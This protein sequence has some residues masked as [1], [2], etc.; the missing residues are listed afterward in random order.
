MYHR[1]MTKKIQ[2]DKNIDLTFKF[3]NYFTHGKNIPETPDN[4]SF[5]PFS[6][7]DKELNIA[8]EE[9]LS[10][11]LKES[12]PVAKAQE[13]SKDKWIITPVNF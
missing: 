1:F 9:L 11:L 10:L 5:V 7:N 6:K 8:N 13:V 3:M 2:A 4:V 12:K